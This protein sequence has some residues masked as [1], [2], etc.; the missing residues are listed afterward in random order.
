VKQKYSSVVEAS[1]EHSLFLTVHWIQIWE[2]CGHIN[3][4][5]KFGIFR[6]KNCTISCATSLHIKL[7][8]LA[9][10]IHVFETNVSEF[11]FLNLYI[12]E[13]GTILLK[14]AHSAS[15]EYTVSKKTTMTFYA[16]TSMHINR[17]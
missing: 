6:D 9:M 14:F 2:F 4:E 12:S 3:R 8:Q 11:N 16:I 17:F 10:G 7:F 15:H 13:T 1:L 5:M